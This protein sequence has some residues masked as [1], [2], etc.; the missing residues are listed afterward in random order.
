MKKRGRALR[1]RYGHATSKE[2]FCKV[3]FSKGA[4]K[5]AGL[6]VPAAKVRGM[7]VGE[8][9]RLFPMSEAGKMHRL[10]VSPVFPTWDA[11]FAFEKP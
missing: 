7:S 8:I 2:G 11:A 3:W 5:T 10:H 6:I 4:E 9:S 1:R